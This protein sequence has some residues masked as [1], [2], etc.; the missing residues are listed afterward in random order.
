MH[1]VERMNPDLGAPQC[2]ICGKGNTPNN[3]QDGSIGPF[4]DLDRE[5]NWGDPA[6]LCIDCGTRIG[7]MFDM[8][9]PDEKAHLERII[10]DKDKQIHDLESKLEQKNRRLKTAE[11]QVEVLAGAEKIKKKKAA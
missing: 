4:L 1:L 9:T 6:Y 5:V 8:I 11:H 10:R 3:A 7:T 2:L